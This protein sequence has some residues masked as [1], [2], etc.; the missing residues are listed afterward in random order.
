M[1]VRWSNEPRLQRRK[2]QGVTEMRRVKYKESRK[3]KNVKHGEAGESTNVISRPTVCQTVERQTEAL[4]F[5]N[6]LYSI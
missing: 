6:L 1:N 5:S 2:R 4:I 3:G